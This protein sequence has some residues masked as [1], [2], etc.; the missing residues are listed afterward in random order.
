MLD[1]GRFIIDVARLEPTGES[2]AG[3]TAPDLLDL[4]E[5]EYVFPQGGMHYAVKV[6]RVA[7]QLLVRGRVGQHIECI[8]S[9][10]AER[11]QSYAEDDEFLEMYEISPQTEFMDLTPELREVIILA[12]PAYP[13]CSDSCS[14]LCSQ[15][16][17]NLNKGRCSCTSEGE[18]HVWHT[19]DSLGF[20]SGNASAESGS[21]S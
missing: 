5:S 10:C 14:G 12:L 18:N 13:L 3:E 19:L 17:A 16:G 6:E 11:F 2:F 7:Q 8:C 1:S 4:G 21:R 20:G 15:C 9:R